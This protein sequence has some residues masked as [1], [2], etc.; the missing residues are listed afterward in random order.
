MKVLI[1]GCG[2]V[3]QVFGLYLQKAGVELGFYDRPE[4]A[5]R[6]KRALGE[7]GLSLFQITYMRRRNPIPHRLENFQVVVDVAESQAFKPDLIWFATPSPVYHSEW[8]HEFLE[9]VPS[10]RVVCFAP[11]GARPEFFPESGGEGRLVFGGFTMIAWQGDLEGSSGKPQGVNFWRPPLVGIPLTGTEKAG[12]QVKELL[13]K[14]GLRAVVNKQDDP[15]SLAAVT[16]VMTAF[17]AGLE[18]SGWS[19]GAYRTS[20]WLKQAARGAR[21]GALSQF[22]RAG[23]FTRALLGM[24]CSPAMFFLLSLLLPLP[25]PFNLGKYLKFHYTKTREQTLTLLDVFARDGERRGLPVENI[26]SLL[27]GLQDSI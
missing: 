14:A 23:V 25:F 10:E 15:K 8:F 1:V 18:L 7:G 27:Q 16:A 3:G 21:E 11:E 4:V 24:L 9:K 2:A 6:L 22:S 12:G 26:R 20:P 17:V 13:K 19:L 5:D